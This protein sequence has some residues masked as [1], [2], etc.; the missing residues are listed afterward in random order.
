[1]IVF[2][3]VVCLVLWF[4]LAFVSVHAFADAYEV[5]DHR[6]MGWSV[7]LFVF[8]SLIWFVVDVVLVSLLRLAGAA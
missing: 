7:L 8:W 4:V 3:H 5:K 6:E 2:F 1:M